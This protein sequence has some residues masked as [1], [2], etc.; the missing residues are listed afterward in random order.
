MEEK[1]VQQVLDTLLP[2]LEALETQSAA[3]LQ[4]L[5]DKGIASEEEVTRYLEQA[6]NAS[7]VRWRAARARINR[8]L[9][10]A[11]Q[12]AEK[13]V[14]KESPKASESSPE[15]VA[16]T[17]A[18]TDL[19]KTEKEVQGVPKVAANT[20]ADESVDA[21]SDDGPNKQRKTNNQPNGDAGKNL[22]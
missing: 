14:Q 7:N 21:N 9:A 17:S 12:P 3:I 4:F 22:A 18:E 20:K 16:N 11:E 2:S 1:V 5:K 15:A 19:G 10:S 6:A 13:A 8:L